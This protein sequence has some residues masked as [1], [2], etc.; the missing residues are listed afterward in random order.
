MDN[1]IYITLSRQV[2]MFN[3]MEMTANNLANVN[4]P[5]YQANKLMFSDYLVKDEDRKTAYANDPVNYR[6][7]TGGAIKTTGNS[8]DVAIDG[9]AYFQVQSPLGIRYTRAGNFQ[10]NAE[11]MLVTTE[12]Y[13]VLGN[14]G[15]P[16]NIPQTQAT[17]ASMAPARSSPMARM[18]ARSA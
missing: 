18:S 11:G 12:G 8:F 10:L 4:T 2:G 13:A 7:T 1:S 3:D 17:C 14:D 9:D 15:G 6:D 16:I 5:G